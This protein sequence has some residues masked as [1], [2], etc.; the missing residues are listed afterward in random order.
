MIILK[1]DNSQQNFLIIPRSYNGLNLTL[2]FTDST[3][4]WLLAEK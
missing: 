2:V 3:Q 4:G 1:P